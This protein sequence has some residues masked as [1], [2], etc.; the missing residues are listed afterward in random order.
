MERYKAR[1]T[2]E[3]VWARP[4]VVSRYGLF[5]GWIV[6]WELMG[7]VDIHCGVVLM[8]NSTFRSIFESY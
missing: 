5:K 4:T 6:L 7:F 2:G 8:G 1:L 3:T